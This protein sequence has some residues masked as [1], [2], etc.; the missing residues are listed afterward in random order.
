MAQHDYD[1]ANDTAANVRADINNVLEAIATQNSGSTA[2]STTYA[3]QWW[4]DTANNILKVRNELNTGWVDFATINQANSRIEFPTLFSTNISDGT[5]TTTTVNAIKG[6]AKAR[7]YYAQNVPST[8]DI[9]N[10]SSITDNGTGD[11]TVNFTNNMST[12]TYTTVG[13]AINT[14]AVNWTA[15]NLAVSSVSCYVHDAGNVRVDLATTGLV[16]GDLA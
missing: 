15:A 16:S 4:Y 8:G 6:S 9:F 13:S 12:S 14:T 7:W 1:I 3:N 5:N 11:H 10:V 2:P